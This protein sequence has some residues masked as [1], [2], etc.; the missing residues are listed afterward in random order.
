[1]T[2]IAKRLRQLR[3]KAGLDAI[4]VAR[5]I[6][7]TPASYSLLESG[8]TKYPRPETLLGLSKFHGVSP[9]WL[10]Y[11]GD[12]EGASTEPAAGLYS[13]PSLKVEVAAG[14]GIINYSEDK[15]PGGFSFKTE[16]L[17]R[18]TSRLNMLR[19]VF[20]DGDSMEPTIWDRDLI[21][22]ELEPERILDRKVYV[23]RWA[24]EARVKRLVNLHDGRIQVSSDND[25]KDL[26]PNEIIDP[27]SESFSVIGQVHW[28]G[29]WI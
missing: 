1:M 17:R 16:S 22:L 11:G 4:E 20:A 28:R 14:S 6:G 3:E 24:D 7:I 9:D 27:R 26:Y 29:G 19:C 10:V 25:D 23:I 2:E 18:I 12:A 8:R 13:V 21:L 5:S 15:I